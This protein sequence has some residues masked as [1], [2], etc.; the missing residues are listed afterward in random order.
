MAFHPKQYTITAT[1]A[2]LTTIMGFAEIKHLKHLIIRNATGATAAL[3]VG[4]SDVLNTPANAGMQIAAGVTEEIGPFDLNA[5]NTEE[6]YLVGTANAAN[7]AYIV[8]VT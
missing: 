8:A 2:K 7:I 1:A 4:K 3:Y 5:I 6:I